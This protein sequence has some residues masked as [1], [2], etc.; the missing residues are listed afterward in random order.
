MW[1]IIKCYVQVRLYS[2]YRASAG[3][4]WGVIVVVVVLRW[5]TQVYDDLV[6]LP[7]IV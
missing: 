1:N 6:R 4:D 5:T 3:V 7:K 2:A